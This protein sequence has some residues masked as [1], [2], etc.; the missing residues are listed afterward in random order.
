[1]H[2]VKDSKY[3]L[4]FS[5]APLSPVQPVSPALSS[6]APAEPDA[7]SPTPGFLAQSSPSSYPQMSLW[8]EI[9]TH[10][11]EC[12]VAVSLHINIGIK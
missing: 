9:Q 11:K 8:K 2:T 5:P 4:P 6:A 3:N 1:M 10:Y 7:S 12:T